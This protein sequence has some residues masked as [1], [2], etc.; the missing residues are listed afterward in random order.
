MENKSREGSRLQRRRGC[1]CAAALSGLRRRA[2]E[3]RPYIGAAAAGSE[4]RLKQPV[5]DGRGRRQIDRTKLRGGRFILGWCPI[6][7]RSAV[8]NYGVQLSRGKT[9]NSCSFILDLDIIIGIVSN[10]K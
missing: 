10:S 5:S 7:I 2:W 9:V 4:R 8:V 1:E 3:Q 6:A